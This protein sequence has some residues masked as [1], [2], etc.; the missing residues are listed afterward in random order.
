MAGKDYYGILGVGRSASA[1]D[2]KSAYRKLAREYHPDVNKAANAA[3][4][5]KEATA[6]YEVLSDPKK[7]QL[8]D[9][10][11][12][13][14][15]EGFGGAAGPGGARVYRWGGRAPPGG[16]PNFEDLFASSPFAGMS[17][18]DLL[19]SL[20][21]RRAGARRGRRAAAHKGASAQ[22]DVTLD[23][24]QAA[25][26]CTTR[27][28][29]TGADGSSQEIDV[30]IPAGVREGSKIRVRGKGN[31]GRGGAG[32]LYLNAHVRRHP[33]FRREGADI[34]VDLP[35]SVAEAAGGATVTVPT[36]DGP[37]DLKVPPGASG[38]TQLRMRGKGVVD[39]RSK[40]RG[41][42]YVVLKIVLPRK[43]SAKGLELLKEFEKTDP[44]DPRESAPW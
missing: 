11:G 34:Y 18:K 24:M 31:P 22:V 13:V 9:Q 35:V 28:Q 40:S 30:K 38:G 14:G 25:R 29:M 21:G 36:I 8:Y 42:Q 19:A 4:K 23:F 7:R 10:F 16:G 12:H 33:Y 32:D 39:P 15:P 1:D 3:E 20:A 26:G 41:D 44:H 2:I 6:A 27:L 37:A 5:F 17:L 43:V